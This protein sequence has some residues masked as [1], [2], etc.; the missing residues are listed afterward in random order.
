MLQ[1][2]FQQIDEREEELLNL[3]KTLVS[4]ETPSPP[5]RNAKEAQKYV[6]SYLED[7]GFSIDQWDLYEQD[8]VVVG[9]K[10]GKDPENYHSLIINGHIDVASIEE[11]EEWLTPPFEATV[12]G[13]YIYG[14]GVADMKGGMAASLF[15]LKLLQEKALSREGISFF[16][17]SSVKK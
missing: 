17:P 7:I 2:L 15:A 1:T 10:K 11:G 16:S 4:F 12:K 8:P 5:A 9:T 6:A 14:R 3:L 13:D